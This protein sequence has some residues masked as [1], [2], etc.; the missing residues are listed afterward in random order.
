[1][2]KKVTLDSFTAE[3]LKDANVLSASEKVTYRIDENAARSDYVQGYTEIKLKNGETKSK[4]I[5]V[6]YG[7]PQNPI[8]AESLVAKFI[9][10]ASYFG[11]KN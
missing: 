1:V 9:N 2:H 5:E 6:V 4:N 10:C 8:D 11:E 7:H 3:A